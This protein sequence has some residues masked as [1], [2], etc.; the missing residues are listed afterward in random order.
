M[1][2]KRKLRIKEAFD[3][4]VPAWLR[5]VLH[6]VAKPVP[7]R[8][9]SG[10]TPAPITGKL[11]L[12]TAKFVHAET[13]V[14]ARDPKW[15]DE[16]IIPVFHGEDVWG[17]KFTWIMGYND[18][19]VSMDPND[20]W[21]HKPIS[22]VAKSKVIDMCNTFGYFI[23]GDGADDV[24][25]KRQSRKDSRDGALDRDLTKA[26]HKSDYSG[27][28]Y[29]AQGYDKSGYAKN[30]DKYQDM[31]AQ[32][33]LERYEEIL[34]QGAEASITC[35]QILPIIRRTYKTSQEKRTVYDIAG[36]LSR[37]LTSAFSELDKYYSEWQEAR[38]D[39]PEWADSYRKG[40]VLECIKSL[41]NYTKKALNFVD[42]V[43]SGAD[44]DEL[45]RKF[46]R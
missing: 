33:N 21:K 13:P 28:W 22:R 24:A 4:S 36:N 3:N 23:K 14:N 38:T 41:R 37:Q 25:A 39:H 32:L 2:E 5:P 45:W 35:S 1:V 17:N 9:G 34:D 26:Q 16:I 19:E 30:P 29:T 27:S 42:A 10:K 40:H 43:K 6:N 12:T 31:L 44:T 11:D 20:R 8:Y 15:S 7:K 46:Y 18:P